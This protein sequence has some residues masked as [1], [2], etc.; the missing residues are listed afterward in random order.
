[1]LTAEALPTKWSPVTT[2]PFILALLFFSLPLSSSGKSIFMVLATV[3][4]LFKPGYLTQIRDTISRPWCKA[5]LAL[6]FLALVAC[7]WSPATGKEKWLILSKYFKFLYLPLLVVAFQDKKAR[8]F[9]IHAF[10]LA[11]AITSF[12]SIVLKFGWINTSVH[13]DAVFRNHIITGL[14][15]SFATYVCGVLFVRQQKPIRFIYLLLALIYTYQIFFISFGRTGYILYFLLLS[16]LVVQLF[17]KRQAI[18]GAIA[19]AGLFAGFFHFSPSM[20]QGLQQIITEWKGFEHDKN[21]SVG[22]RIQFHD[23]SHKLFEH[24]PLIG[25]G[26]GSFTALYRMEKPVPAWDRTLLEPHSQYWLTAVEFGLLG[27]AVL[28]FFFAALFFSAWHLKQMRPIAI[29][30]LLVIGV[31][32]LTDSM[33]LYSGPGYFFILWMGLC[34]GEEKRVEG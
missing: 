16:L 31:S 11:M 9:S 20:Q 28:G 33:L 8:N 13:P 32:S 25:N 15:M 14:M 27:L 21:T 24:H 22:Y 1:M 6:F 29:S 19:L 30:L 34:L 23:F 4:I 2:I 3:V 7:L 17:T 5:A 12:I 26:T 10:L 18:I